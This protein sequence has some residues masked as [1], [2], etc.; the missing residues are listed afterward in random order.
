MGSPG[1]SLSAG[2]S[3]LAG[4]QY[5][6]SSEDTMKQSIEAE[7]NYIFANETQVIDN[8]EASR[9]SD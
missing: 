4:H 8:L 1:G 2:G 9:T 6:Q 5:L 7:L 3:G